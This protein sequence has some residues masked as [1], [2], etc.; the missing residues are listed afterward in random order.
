MSPH[1]RGVVL[2]KNGSQYVY[3]RYRYKAEQ[4]AKDFFNHQIFKFSF[5]N[6]WMEFRKYHDSILSKVEKANQPTSLFLESGVQIDLLDT[7]RNF[8][9]RQTY[10]D[11][12][13]SYVIHT[14]SQL[15]SHDGFYDDV[16]SGDTWVFVDYP[17]KLI[18]IDGE[19][20]FKKG[21]LEK[22]KPQ[23][24]PMMVNLKKTG[25]DYK[26]YGIVYH[27]MESFYQPAEIVM[28]YHEYVDWV[29]KYADLPEDREDPIGAVNRMIGYE[30]NHHGSSVRSRWRNAI[31]L[32]YKHIALEDLTFKP[33]E[34]PTDFNVVDNGI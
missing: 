30:F 23:D 21:V 18:Y 3:G 17:N 4:A 6:I 19:K 14:I 5:E 15:G 11:F 13:T 29:Q 10:R 31:D 12:I 22:D 7:K 25:S 26:S 27:A 1:D 24:T 33:V 9:F 8:S 20:I 32:N 2:F 28:F 34:I 16:N